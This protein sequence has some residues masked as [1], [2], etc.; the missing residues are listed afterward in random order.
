MARQPLPALGERQR[1]SRPA[2]LRALGCGAEGG[3]VE[4]LEPGCRSRQTIGIS[5][6]RGDMVEEVAE[7]SD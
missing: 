1:Q 3:K 5:K 4:E 2:G 7:V 6:T